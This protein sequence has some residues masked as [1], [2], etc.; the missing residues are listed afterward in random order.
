MPAFG[1]SRPSR[2]TLEIKV[3][4]SETTQFRPT[5]DP[6]PSTTLRKS[7]RFA[8]APSTEMQ[9][10]VT[11]EQ[12]NLNDIEVKVIETAHPPAPKPKRVRNRAKKV[13]KP[14]NALEIVPVVTEIEAGDTGK[15]LIHLMISYNQNSRIQ[16]QVTCNQK[17]VTFQGPLES[18]KAVSLEDSV[19]PIPSK[20]KRGRPSKKEVEARVAA[21]KAGV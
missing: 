20:S 7:P 4:V 14:T 18:A 19:T 1:D 9:E 11:K 16:Y 15:S 10:P 5:M 8:I 2:A 17:Q 3:W 6:P 21:E 12:S 13:A